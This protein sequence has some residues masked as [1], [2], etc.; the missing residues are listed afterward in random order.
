MNIR[1]NVEK[2]IT[3]LILLPVSISFVSIPFNYDVRIFQGAARLTDYFGSFPSNIDGAWEIKPI[4]NRLI[5]YGLYKIASGFALVSTPEYEML[6]KA[7][8]LAAVIVIC[9]YFSSKFKQ[10][11]LFLVSCLAFLVIG[12]QV[13]L[14]P[15]WFA[16]LL[17]LLAI[18]LLRGNPRLQYIA[19]FVI[20]CIFL[21]KGITLLLVIPIVGMTLLYCEK[22]VA[23]IL[24]A[25]VSSFLSVGVV[26]ASGLFPHLVPDM[27]MSGR[28]AHIGY[29]SILEMATNLIVGSVSCYSVIYIP[30]IFAG[31]VCI[32]LLYVFEKP[33]LK[34]W[35]VLLASWITC[36]FIVFIQSECFFAYQYF[37]L[38]LPAL[39]TV[40]MLKSKGVVVAIVCVLAAFIFILA[41]WNGGL[42]GIEYS[43]SASERDAA[44]NLT[45]AFPDILDQPS[46]LYLDVG[47][48]PYYLGVNSTSRYILMSPF[49]RNSSWWDVS[50]LPQYHEAY[51]DIMN[52]D[53][54]YIIGAT[55]ESGEWM[56]HDT[57]DNKRVWDK[58]NSEY[59][60]VWQ[61][62]WVL[63]EK[64]VIQGI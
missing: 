51:S 34:D 21:L 11:Y 61:G 41:A 36:V 39:F 49:Q 28:L 55:S 37:V 54:K 43:Y 29:F 35:I 62:M 63:Y 22:P 3:F 5:H 45:G 20:A 64:K 12:S 26:I 17:S 23:R 9:W 14:Q 58:I 2:I 4:G 46:M 13:A 31:L 47:D 50:D 6:A 53:G 10:P 57:P 48:A 18:A 38:A 24:K 16:V 56:V 25:G 19:G 33:A 32:P 15:E 7:I 40:C 59:S 8:C 44:I 27:L 1:S 60:I 30:I 52:Y 42:V